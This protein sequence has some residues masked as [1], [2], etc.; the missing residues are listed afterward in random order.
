MDDV[1]TGICEV[2]LSKADLAAYRQ[3]FADCVVLGQDGKLLLQYRPLDWW[4][5][6]GWYTAF[7]GH[8]DAGESVIQALLRELHEELGAQVGVDDVVF[9]GALTEAETEHQEMV[10]VYFWHDREGRITGCYE[11][12]ARSFDT[13]AA[14]LAEPKIMDYLK[15]ALQKGKSLGFLP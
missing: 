1:V 8:V 14:A 7:G 9:L 4:T 11:A 10:H 5:K 3:H 13:V 2:D 6:P 15:W 12:E